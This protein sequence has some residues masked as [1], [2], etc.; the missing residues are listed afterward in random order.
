MGWSWFLVPF[1][2]VFVLSAPVPPE[3]SRNFL[4]K[5]E[6]TFMQFEPFADGWM[7]GSGSIVTANS[8]TFGLLTHW[9]CLG[10]A[11]AE[12]LLCKKRKKLTNMFWRFQGAILNRY[13]LNMSWFLSNMSS[14]GNWQN[15]VKLPGAKERD[16][17]GWL[18]T[19]SAVYVGRG[20]VQFVCS[21]SVY[22]LFFSF[23]SRSLEG[24]RLTLG[25]PQKRP[26]WQR[27]QFVLDRTNPCLQQSSLRVIFLVGTFWAFNWIQIALCLIFQQLARESSSNLCE[28]RESL[29]IN[30]LFWSSNLRDED[31]KACL[32]I[33]CSAR[34]VDN[35]RHDRLSGNFVF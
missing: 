16:P 29:F 24:A 25:A 3:L 2:L 10:P 19:S 6:S 1:V 21:S 27:C 5:Q 14:T 9:K 23:F 13:D 11:P 4:L 32:S 22:L 26:T 35:V 34:I 31:K 7:I 20:K 33:N 8:P 15:C 28:K 17:W 12:G 30:K 18:Y